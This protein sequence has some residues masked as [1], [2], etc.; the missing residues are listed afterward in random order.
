M[1]D[2]EIGK[3]PLVEAVKT[4]NAEIIYDYSII[5]GMALRVPNGSDIHK[6]IAYFKSVTGAVS[7]ECDRINI[8]S[9]L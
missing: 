8:L 1:Y 6:W 7:V 2:L 9:S 5:P 4:M 3:E